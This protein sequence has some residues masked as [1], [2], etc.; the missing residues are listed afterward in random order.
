VNLQVRLLVRDVHAKPPSHAGDG[1]AKTTL[2][3]AQCCYQDDI[4]RDAML[5]PSQLDRGVKSRRVILMITLLRQLGR[6]AVSRRFE[7]QRATESRLSHET[8]T[9][10]PRRCVNMEIFKYGKVEITKKSFPS[11]LAV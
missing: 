2:A 7:S 4:S 9:D 8:P 5:K 6:C 3:V 1:N 10:L 11:F